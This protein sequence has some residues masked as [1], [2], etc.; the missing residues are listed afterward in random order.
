MALLET[1]NVDVV[2]H[3]NIDNLSNE[4][5]S[6]ILQDWRKNYMYE[7]DGIIVADDNAHPRSTG[8]PEHTFAFKMVLS[9]QMAE[10]QV[11]DVIWTASKDGYLKPRVQIMPV[12][13]GG[14]TIQYATGFNGSFIQDN[15]IG[16]GAIIQIIRSGDV[17]PKIQSVT[18]PASNA[19]MPDV[20]Y[21][22]N[23]THVDVMLQDATGNAVVI[24]KNITGFFKGIGV[25]GLGPG[26]VEKM[27]ASGFDSIPKIL[28][29]E[30][31]D[32][33][34]VDG[35]KDKTATKLFEGIRDKTATASLTTIMAESNKLGR[36]FSSK[37]AELILSEY[38][39]VFEEGE[40]NVTR[41]VKIKG[42]EKKSAQA[43]VDH[44]PDFLKFLEECGLQE[45]LN[46]KSVTPIVMDES[47]PLF[48]KPIVLTGF[49]DKEL[50]EKVKSVGAKIGSTVSKNTFVVLVKDVNES[51][52]KVE[53]ARLKNIPIMTPEKF[54]NK[55]F[56]NT[57]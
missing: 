22:W 30:K 9:D 38:P 21:I 46:I 27:V 19:K 36:G 7:I 25:D 26:N 47:H 23:D 56:A 24:E 49:R 11:V 10:S 50:E 29:M 16:I 20:D 3:K 15:K 8:N 54:T 48:G 5:L 57:I 32:F 55:Y 1:M 45:K 6:E 35:F 41:L 18:T 34:K 33:L 40:R 44:I 37:R 51:N 12:K 28:R 39:T 31:A 2:Q 53:D 42:I 4:Y 13:L 52:N 14:V 17:I 43:F